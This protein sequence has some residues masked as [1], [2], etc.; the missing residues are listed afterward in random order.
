M[1]EG[2]HSDPAQQRFEDYR[3]PTGPAPGLQ[4]IWPLYGAGFENLGLEGRPVT[5]DVP[6]FG[7]DEL[8]VRHDATGLCYSD[9]KV[10]RQG[11]EHP[12]IHRDMSAQPVILGHEVSMTVVGVGK[13]L[14]DQVRVG[15]RFVVQADIFVNGMG[16]AY[17]Y[18]IQGGLSQYSII[19]GRILC[20]DGGNYLVPV[21]PA[22]GYAEAAL[23]EP[24]A[25][26][27]AA[28]SLTYRTG[29]KP[30]GTTWIVN[31][32]KAQ[33]H[34]V[35]PI[36][37]IGSGL[38]RTSHPSCIWLTNVPDRFAGWL[39]RQALDLEIQVLDVN[40]A[41]SPPP[42]LVDDIIL[43]G[44][45]ADLTEEVSER[46][47]DSGVLAVI[48]E[49]P[50]ARRIAVD[51]GRIHY[52]H[53]LYVGGPGPDIA[54]AYSQVPVRSSLR[55]GGRAWFLG[56]GGPLGRMHLQRAM[57]LRDGPRTILCT[58]VS[59][60]RLDGLRT[61]FAAEAQAK[62]IE[63]VCVNP[64]ADGSYRSR[65]NA[66]RRQGFDDIVILA[67]DSAAIAD[68]ATFLAPLGVMNIFAGIARGATASL[69]L[70]AVAL[71]GVR[72]IGHSASTIAD[73]RRVLRQTEL[74]Q[75][76]P[77]HSVAAVG[78]L[79]AA[80]DGLLAVRDAVLPGKAVIYPNIREMPLTELQDLKDILPTVHA[81]LEN[82]RT[83]TGQAE[84][85]FLRLMLPQR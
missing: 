68:A 43:L 85:E 60:Q 19:D 26:V 84:A 31:A 29:L 9:V 51:V 23:T 16:L 50:L 25:C 71:R 14:R 65:M 5:I 70:G 48:A 1:D 49:S 72:F 74:G 11:P 27:V 66:L 52:N 22:I 35:L 69:D 6:S 38:D 77:N 33:G 64:L 12:R 56:A 57:R 39:R 67:P 46:L 40:D 62:G 24:W 55:P 83:W 82:G 59:S 58:D 7:P 80:R 36:Y 75:I 81:K 41:T 61:S 53:W 34:E 32:W 15:D 45:D 54:R 10:I 2:R 42:G 13:N 28:Y 44:A 8:L 78:S 21:P 47:A 79:A 73:I 76:L 63:L 37:T 3:R 20:G 17:G 18:E 4:Q 30:G